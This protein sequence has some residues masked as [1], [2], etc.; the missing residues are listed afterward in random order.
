MVYLWCTSTLPTWLKKLY[1]SL[2]ST[3]NKSNLPPVDVLLVYGGQHLLEKFHHTRVFTTNAIQL[4]DSELNIRGML[5]NASGDTGVDHPRL[6]FPVLC[7]LPRDM[8][9]YIQRRGR[10]GRQGQESVFISLFPLLILCTLQHK[11]N[12][13]CTRTT[14]TR[15]LMQMNKWRCAGP[16]ATS[17]TQCALLCHLI[18]DVCIVEWNRFVLMACHRFVP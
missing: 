15:T 14:T 1:D 17:T 5:A 6:I 18:W 16:N 13:R 3:L 9:S 12:L 7:Q 4:E 8:Q 10:L 2:K 11:L